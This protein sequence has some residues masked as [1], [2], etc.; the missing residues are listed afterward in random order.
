ML[1]KLLVT[2]SDA[3][4]DST[5]IKRNLDSYFSYIPTIKNI[6]I[7]TGYKN[8][9]ETIVDIYAYSNNIPII[10]F[11]QENIQNRNMHMLV[12]ATT[13]L[14]LWDGYCI[15]MEELQALAEDK[16]LPTT[17]LIL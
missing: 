10:Y 15:E 8:K 14:L 3:I 16:S 12:D 9:V 2:G 17:I 7:L 1:N 11:E 13:V 4:T 6:I 5:L